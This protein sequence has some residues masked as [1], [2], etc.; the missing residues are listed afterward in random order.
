MHVGQL[1]AGD[2]IGCRSNWVMLQ[3]DVLHWSIHKQQLVE[4]VY[5][6]D[7]DVHVDV[8]LIQ[9]HVTS[10][11]HLAIRRESDGKT[12]SINMHNSY[13]LT[14]S[15]LIKLKGIYSLD[16]ALRYWNPPK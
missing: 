12:M 10:G 9:A 1:V 5:I 14:I 8:L 2:L 4:F 7:A 11:G 15:K 6:V 13:N 16:K 3:A